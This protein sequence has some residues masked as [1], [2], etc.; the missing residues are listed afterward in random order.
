MVI[1]L[2]KDFA[3]RGCTVIVSTHDAEM[4]SASDTQHEVGKNTK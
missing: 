3:I 1:D 4:I 2:F